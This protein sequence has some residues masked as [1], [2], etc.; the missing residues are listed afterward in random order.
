MAVLRRNR[1]HDLGNEGGDEN[2]F[3]CFG[4]ESRGCFP[5]LSG[6]ENGVKTVWVLSVLPELSDFASTE[7][8]TCQG[9]AAAPRKK[10]AAVGMLIS[11]LAYLIGSLIVAP[12]LWADP[13]S[14]MFKVLP[15]MTL[16]AMV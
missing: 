15:G 13:L 2:D 1:F 14:P 9:F 12:D 4:V 3:G 16:A 11:S 5:C 8:A 10:R 7:A 6:L